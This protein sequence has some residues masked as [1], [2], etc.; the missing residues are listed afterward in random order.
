MADI[1]Y[2]YFIYSAAQLRDRTNIEKQI[3]K[4]FIRG[5]VVVGSKSRQYTELSSTGVSRYSD[6][7]IVAEGNVSQMSYTKIKSI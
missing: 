3:G 2:K 1:G 6:A 5:S 4:Q 7:V